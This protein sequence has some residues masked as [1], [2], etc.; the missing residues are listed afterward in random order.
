MRNKPHI[1]K[2]AFALALFGLVAVAALTGCRG[3]VRAAA[4]TDLIIEDDVVYVA[5]LEQVRALDV[6]S[7]AVLWSFPNEPNAGS[8]G[9]FYT[10]ALA[11]DEALFVTSEEKLRGG[12]FAQPEG[13]LR[14]LSLVPEEPEGRRE[15]WNFTEAGGDYVGGGAASDG[16][17]IFGN[18][19]GTVYA[20]DVDNGALAWEF[21]TEGRVWATPLI[22][23]GTVYVASLDHTL[24]ALDLQTGAEQWRFTAEGA[25]AER[26]LVLDGRLYI[27][28]FDHTLYAIEDGE[29]V[30]EL[31]GQNWFWGTPTTDGTNIYAV[32]VDGNVY[33]ADAETGDPVW[34]SQVNDLV[35]LGPVVT[36]DGHMVIVASNDGAIYGLDTSDGVVLWSKPGDGQIASLTIEGEYIYVTRINAEERVQ[37]FY[38]ENGRNFWA[39]SPSESE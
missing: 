28:S 22:V 3:G 7:G 9:P 20:L 33:A 11:P 12:F 24:Y 34:D 1:L 27:G 26:P 36:E 14:A 31:E 16:I 6:E 19:D 32:D 23:D 17:V 4:W 5:D 8:Y 38:A 39:F 21:A 15:L 30:W 25:L 18:G 13:V 37:A 35:H 10:L 29:S 2:R